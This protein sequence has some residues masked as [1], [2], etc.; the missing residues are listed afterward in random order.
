MPFK[1]ERLGCDSAAAA[2]CAWRRSSKPKA[3]LCWGIAG[4]STLQ[5][6][7]RGSD[8]IG[9]GRELVVH[10]LLLSV[11]PFGDGGSVLRCGFCAVRCPRE[12]REWPLSGAKSVG[13]ERQ[14]PAA[15]AAF[16]AA[17]RFGGEARLRD[18]C[19][20]RPVPG[21]SQ[22][23]AVRAGSRRPRLSFWPD[24]APDGQPPS[25]SRKVARLILD[26]DLSNLVRRAAQQLQKC[27]LDHVFGVRSIAHHRKRYA[28]DQPGVLLDHLVY[29]V[30]LHGLAR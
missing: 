29:G 4:Q 3:R 28:I 6:L 9:C 26:R 24:I 25:D 30:A 27:L 1:P 13:R 23:T 19:R 5:E 22:G 17:R 10:L 11:F 20:A 8:W 2:I 21:S 16:P 14:G 15:D 7:S 18:R 12:C